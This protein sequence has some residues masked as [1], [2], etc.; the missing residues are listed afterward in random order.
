MDKMRK[1]IPRSLRLVRGDTVLGTIEVKPGA[2]DF[3]WYSGAFHPSAGFEAVRD[4][5]EEEL[6]LIKENSSDDSVLW[7]E[8]E[9]LH[10]QLHD[11]GLRLESADKSYRAGEI[12]IHINGSEAW[13][14][15][16]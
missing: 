6:R 3:P 1:E 11:P 7:D 14:R 8:W 15:D 16:E 13:W 9:A 10:A 5:F 4:L 12:L 2:D